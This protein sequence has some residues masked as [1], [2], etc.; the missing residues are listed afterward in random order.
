MAA[1]LRRLCAVVVLVAVAAVAAG[2]SAAEAAAPRVTVIADSVGGAL[3]W[4]GDARG[5]LGRGL[6]LDLEIATCRKLDGPGCAYQGGR[7]PSAVDV[8]RT[9]SAPL[10]RVV[11]VNVGYNDLA[12]TYGDGL[13]RLMKTL[14][15][16]GVDR[17]VWVTMRETTS[18]YTAIN[19]EIRQGARRWPQLVVADWNAT[20]SD[21]DP[22]F[23]DGV[24]LSYE[25]GL[26]FARFLRPLVI[27][28]CGAACR[29]GGDLL[30]VA[31]TKL[32]P[33]QAR[34]PFEGRI[35]VSGGTTP[36]RITVVGLP[37]PLRMTATG[38]VTGRP[39]SSG[40]FRL[41]V[42]VTDAAGIAT[43]GTVLLRVAPAG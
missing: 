27:S 35:R 30:A 25:G 19:A 11:V 29:V 8:A 5:A 17:V 38:L 32:G 16:R 3:S 39:A 13:D 14:T 36:Y 1:G 42:R 24:H 18:T 22:W 12:T 20:S 43:I 10:G 31:T 7:P 15:G 40:R 26:A 4:M 34:R 6:D 9:R 33:A 37:R 28:A 21:A 41:S 2:T 23:T